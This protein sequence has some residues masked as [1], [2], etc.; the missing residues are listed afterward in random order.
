MI[1]TMI[2]H[3]LPSVW[4]SA[5]RKAQG[6]WWQFQEVVPIISNNTSPF[7]KDTVLFCQDN[8]S[9]GLWSNLPDLTLSH[10]LEKPHDHP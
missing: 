7:P 3:A 10:R 2:S 1:I 4:S 8:W 5:E 9:R 6:T